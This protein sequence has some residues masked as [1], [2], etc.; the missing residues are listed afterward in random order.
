MGLR[1]GARNACIQKRNSAARMKRLANASS[2]KARA[3][4]SNAL[5]LPERGAQLA[6]TLARGPHRLDEM[7]L[8]LRV[9]EHLE[10]ALGGAAAR[11]HL[12]AKL[13]RSLAAPTKVQS[14][15]DRAAPSASPSERAASSSASIA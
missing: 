13:R 8:H 6:R 9:L 5:V 1:A 11:G 4:A 2:R 12:G 10:R 14:A 15:S 3:W 7:A